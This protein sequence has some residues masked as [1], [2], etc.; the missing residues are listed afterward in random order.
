[1]TKKPKQRRLE[2]GPLPSRVCQTSVSVVL[3]PGVYSYE[4]IHK[5]PVV[6]LIGGPQ[7]PH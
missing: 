2:R 1:M 6:W 7:I 5:V 3:A 4:Q